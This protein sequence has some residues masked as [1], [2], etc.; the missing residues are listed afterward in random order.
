MGKVLTGSSVTRVSEKG[1][2]LPGLVPFVVN[3]IWQSLD[4]VVMSNT[5]DIPW[6][7]L[8]FFEVLS[9]MESVLCFNQYGLKYLGSFFYVSSLKV[10]HRMN[11]ISCCIAKYYLLYLLTIC[12]L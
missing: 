9:V 5:E 11:K 6:V 4:S 8:E 3:W 12:S 10:S 7:I 2:D 1:M